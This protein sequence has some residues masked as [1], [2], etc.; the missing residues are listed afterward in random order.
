M[1]IACSFARILNDLI[2][3]I[4]LWHYLVGSWGTIVGKGVVRFGF[5]I[6]NIAYWAIFLLW[7]ARR[8]LNP[9]DIAVNRF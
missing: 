5:E 6:K 7:W 9:H 8:D 1:A 2:N 3:K 4:Y